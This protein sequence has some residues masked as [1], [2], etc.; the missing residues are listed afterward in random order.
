MSE[1]GVPIRGAGRDPRIDVFRGLALVMIFINHVPGTI[2]EL[3]TS[4]NFGF[5]DAAE[6]FVLMSGVA[7]GLAYGPMFAQG[8]GRHGISRVWGRA[9]TLYIVHLATT[10]WALGISAG[11]ALFFGV[12]RMIEINNIGPLL[13]DPLAVLVGIPL[14]GHQLGYVNILPLYAVLLLAVPLFLLLGLRRP[15]LL[16]GLSLLLWIA[17][18][19]FRLN[20][21]NFPNPGGW[22]FNP[23]AWQLLF[24]IGLLTGL[25]M[26]QGERFVKIR[27]W[28]VLLCAAY[29][30]MALLWVQWPP[31]GRLGRVVLADLYH[32]GWPFYIVGFD[33]TFLTLP[34]LLH[35]LALAYLLSALPVVQRFCASRAAA[36]LALM[37]R[38]GLAVFAL[39]TVLSILLQALK[40]GGLGGLAWDTVLILGGLAAQLAL[41][42]AREW[43]RKPALKTR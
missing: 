18:G 11:A 43:M 39:G 33:K 15:G 8:V 20:L 28:L 23:F 24:V 25:A 12:T 3:F 17:A 10:A 41:A 14:L 37:G 42:A 26:K 31:A 4:R 13:R 6:A 38:H 40:A 21:P 32:A 36:P 30:I 2:Y 35:I 1:P 29:L 19:Q 22:F 16:L 7:A 9:W 34:R 5:S 27:L